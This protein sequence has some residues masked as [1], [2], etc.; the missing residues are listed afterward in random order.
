MQITNMHSCYKMFA[1]RFKSNHWMTTMQK[2]KFSTF[3]VLHINKESMKYRFVSSTGIPGMVHDKRYPI[4][5]SAVQCIWQYKGEVRDKSSHKLADVTRNNTAEINRGKRVSSKLILPSLCSGENLYRQSSVSAQ[6]LLICQ[7]MR[8][9]WW[10]W[11]C[12]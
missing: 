1:L 12:Y 11:H 4:A 10:S 3:K 6:M 2:F 9:L 5:G 7:D 8:G